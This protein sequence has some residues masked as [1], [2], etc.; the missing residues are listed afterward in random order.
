LNSAS[1]T[2]VPFKATRVKRAL[3]I[4]CARTPSEFVVEA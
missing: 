4:V 1:V 3:E 2:D